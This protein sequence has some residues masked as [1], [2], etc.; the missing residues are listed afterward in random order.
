MVTNVQRNLD[1]FLWFT[2][3]DIHKIKCWVG[4]GRIFDNFSCVFFGFEFVFV[5]FWGVF[6][7][8]LVFV[9]GFFVG[10]LVFCFIL[11][12]KFLLHTGE[13]S[14][15]VAEYTHDVSC[16]WMCPICVK[17]TETNGNIPRDFQVYHNTE[18]ESLCNS[19]LC[20][21]PNQFATVFFSAFHRFLCILGRAWHTTGAVV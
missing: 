6:L 3:F 18:P 4:L 7:G 17:S 12:S 8:F 13:V 9:F 10:W 21:H 19:W 1:I 2:C 11:S 16:S 15:C 20:A 14:L 5:L